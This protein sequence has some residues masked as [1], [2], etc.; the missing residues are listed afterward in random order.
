M[1]I[2]FFKQQNGLNYQYLGNLKA[3][4]NKNIKEEILTQYLRN[5]GY[6]EKLTGKA[7][8]Q[9]QQEAG[10]LNQGLYAANKKVY[11]L[12][13]YGAK[14]SVTP[15]Q[16]PKTVY[17]LIRNTRWTTI[18]PLQKK[19]RWWKRQKSVRIWSFTSMALQ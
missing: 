11:S 5:K 2:Q 1:V 9:L 7:I 14:V 8:A 18:L 6:S 3:V 12:L 17:S 19:S 13:K 15:T 16:P 4:A 10:K